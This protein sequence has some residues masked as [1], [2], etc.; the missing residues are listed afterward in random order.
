M[1]STL[2]TPAAPSAPGP[3][4]G[5]KLAEA[6]SYKQVPF[7]QDMWRRFRRNRLALA[8]SIGV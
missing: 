1:S 7:A 5:A 8:G 2:P 3:V 4:S 6:K